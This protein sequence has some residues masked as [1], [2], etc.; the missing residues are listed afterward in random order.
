M[1]AWLAASVKVAQVRVRSFAGV[2]PGSILELPAGE[3]TEASKRWVP[4]DRLWIC[5][6]GGVELPCRGGCWG[7][8][9]VGGGGKVAGWYGNHCSPRIVWVPRPGPAQARIGC[10][11]KA[12]RIAVIGRTES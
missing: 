4:G 9:G 7:T 10:P 6:Q 1:P 11:W 2:R 12:T 5:W 8:G 3:V